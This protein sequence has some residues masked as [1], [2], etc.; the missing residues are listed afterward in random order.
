MCSFP[1]SL[2]SRR[3]VLLGRRERRHVQKAPTVC[4][5]CACELKEFEHL[6]YVM[7]QVWLVLTLIAQLLRT[8]ELPVP[9]KEKSQGLRLAHSFHWEA[10]SL[11]VEVLGNQFT[12]SSSFF[13]F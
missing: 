13:F 1:G 10:A 2:S 3:A 6:V 5:T 11:S 8:K 12:S 4:Q 7:G 9:G